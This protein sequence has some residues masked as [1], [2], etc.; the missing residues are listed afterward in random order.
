MNKRS[1][2]SAECAFPASGRPDPGRCAAATLDS[3]AG[4]AVVRAAKSGDE[5][6]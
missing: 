3:T 4:L 6:I 2:P 5:P 1:V